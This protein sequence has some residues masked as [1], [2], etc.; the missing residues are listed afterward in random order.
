MNKPFQPEI[1]NALE[2]L[3][4]FRVNGT[5]CNV[6]A[7]PSARLADVLRDKLGLTGTKIGCNSGDCG[8]CTVLLEGDQVCA[9]LTALGQVE[10]RKVTTVEGLAENGVMSRLQQAFHRHG[11]AQCGI[12]TPGM[13]MAATDLLN[14]NPRPSEPEVLEA[15]GGVLCRC[16]GYRKIIEAILD[17]AHG[18]T[19]PCTSMA[20][21]MPLPGEA[22][23]TRVSK[24]DGIAK[25]TG[26]E[27]FGADNIPADALWLRVVRT[28]MR[29]RNLRLAISRRCTRQHP[30][31]VR[32]LTAKD[33]PSNGFGIY[34]TVKDQP[35]L[36]D[37]EVRFPGEA[38]LRWSA[39][40]RRLRRFARTK[41]RFR[42]DRNNRANVAGRDRAATQR[43]FKTITRTIC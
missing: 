31:L 35:V 9:C 19:L 23:G 29:V 15:L 20:P 43:L 42:I 8:A 16:T 39:S 11:G 38:I 6:V 34:P 27:Q 3:I 1:A 25:L 12:C 41:F 21:K 28:N 13:L 26:R 17:V 4:S 30:G 10:G 22:V 37:G 14:K 36:A 24:V 18:P 40:A 2:H 5:E 33:V 7:E 32:V